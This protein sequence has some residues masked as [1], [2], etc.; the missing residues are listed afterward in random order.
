M[1]RIASDGKVTTVARGLA[2]PI[3]V[4]A[5]PD[6]ACFVAESVAG[7]VVHLR[8][9]SITPVVRG[10]REPHGLALHGDMLFVLDRAA[11]TLTQ[12]AQTSGKCELI[13]EN[14]PAS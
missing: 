14:L 5:L 11:K 4:V 12:F 7:R 1:I 13:A 6:G 8:G 3:G 10:L 2:G 9:G